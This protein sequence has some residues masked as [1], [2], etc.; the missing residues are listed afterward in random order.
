MQTE[1]QHV[2]A[3]EKRK[4][5]ITAEVA[6][7]EQYLSKLTKEINETRDLCRQEE[8]VHEST[9][10]RLEEETSEILL[11]RADEFLSGDDRLK[12]KEEL[13]DLRIKEN[14]EKNEV[15]SL[16]IE[17]LNSLID[18]YTALLSKSNL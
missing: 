15:L 3:L 11:R 5:E 13:L 2:K 6:S 7:A 10:K 18:R 1:K 16:T 8:L 12:K 4:A 17:E 9:R 14:I